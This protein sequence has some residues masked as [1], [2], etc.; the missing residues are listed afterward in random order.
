[1]GVYSGSVKEMTH[2]FTR[3]PRK[4]AIGPTWHWLLLTDKDVRLLVVEYAAAERQPA[5]GL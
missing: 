3:G 5:C 2:V 1:M 4:T